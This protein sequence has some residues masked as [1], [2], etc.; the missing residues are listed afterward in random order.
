MPKNADTLTGTN[1][2][3]AI[4]VR[5]IGEMR[6]ATVEALALA[7][8]LASWPLVVEAVTDAVRLAYLDGVADGAC[9]DDDEL[10]VGRSRADRAASIADPPPLLATFAEALS[11]LAAQRAQA[12]G[13]LSAVLGA[14]GVEAGVDVGELLEIHSAAWLGP[15]LEQVASV[16]PPVVVDAGRRALVELAELVARA[17][18]L[19]APS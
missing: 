12:A 1:Q 7:A 19:E 11:G 16:Q 9:E 2:A 4:A 18:T 13:F 15:A 6:D 14:F 8:V 3:A 10:A 17:K 5:L